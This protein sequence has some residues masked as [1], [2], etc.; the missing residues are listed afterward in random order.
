MLAR[1][2]RRGAVLGLALTLYPIVLVPFIKVS[3]DRIDV[4]VS[5]VIVILLISVWRELTWR[6]NAVTA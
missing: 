5:A 3:M 1:H 6:R 2:E 4:A